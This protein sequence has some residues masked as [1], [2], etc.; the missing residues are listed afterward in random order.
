M[1]TV[2]VTDPEWA[3]EVVNTRKGTDG[4]KWT[5]VWDGMIVMPT[6]PNDEHQEVQG[7]LMLPLLL[8]LEMTGLGKVRAGVNVTDRHPDWTDNYR[9]PDLVVYLA[10][11][12]A[13]NHGS[14]WL[15]G[16]DLAVEIIS[17]GE[18]PAG[19]LDFYAGV[20][21]REVLVI[22]RYPW[23]LELYQLRGGELVSAGRSDLAAPAVLAS[24]VLPLAFALR[25]AQPRP[26]VDVTHTA[27][28]QTW[29][30]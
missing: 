17:P 4:D 23:A 20:N 12:P 8:L 24:G 19:K 14:H 13:V 30:A 26:V 15:G 10:G 16:P 18:D 2:M 1:P 9:G 27:T 22:D 7:R 5:E 29:A 28:G 11:N 21:T 3:A 6:L 25:D